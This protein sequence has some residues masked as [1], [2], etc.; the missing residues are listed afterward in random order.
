M[1]MGHAFFLYIYCLY[2]YN[3]DKDRG[4]FKLVNNDLVRVI[5]GG[6]SMERID[7][8]G[9]IVLCD[10]MGYRYL[11]SCSVDELVGLYEEYC[12]SC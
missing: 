5:F 10:G 3:K 6:I 7:D 1:V 2:G 8:G 11:D 9:R 4:S 12:R